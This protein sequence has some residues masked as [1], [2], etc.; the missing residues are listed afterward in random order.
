MKIFRLQKQ[1]FLFFLFVFFFCVFPVFGSYFDSSKFTLEDEIKAKIRFDSTRGGFRY[2]I[3]S[4]IRQTLMGVADNVVV[5]DIEE[6]MN[7]VLQFYFRVPDSQR[8]ASYLKKMHYREEFTENMEALLNRYAISGLEISE[9]KKAIKEKDAEIVKLKVIQ[10]ET[11]IQ[12]TEENLVLE[13]KIKQ[14]EAQNQTLQTQIRDVLQLEKDKQDLNSRLADLIALHRKIALA[15][16]EAVQ[17]NKSITLTFPDSPSMVVYPQPVFETKLLALQEKIAEL[18]KLLK[19]ANSNS[20]FGDKIK[21]NQDFKIDSLES[22]IKD[23]EVKLEENRKL[24]QEQ[25][26]FFQ[27][28]NVLLEAQIKINEEFFQK[29]KK[30]LEA[31]IKDN[32]KKFKDDEKLLKEQNNLL[33]SQISKLE[34]DLREKNNKLKSLLVKHHALEDQILYLTNDLKTSD[35]FREQYSLCVVELQDELAKH[36]S[37]QHDLDLVQE[38]FRN[39]LLDYS[40]L[41]AYKPYLEEELAKAL[42]R[43]SFYEDSHLK[44]LQSL[45]DSLDEERTKIIQLDQEKEDLQKRILFEKEKEHLKRTFGVFSLAQD[46]FN[47]FLQFTQQQNFFHFAPY[48]IETKKIFKAY[49]NDFTFKP[50]YSNRRFSVLFLHFC[51]NFHDVFAFQ[52]FRSLYVDNFQFLG[53]F[54]FLKDFIHQCFLKYD[55]LFMGYSVGYKHYLNSLFK[56]FYSIFAVIFSFIYQLLLHIFPVV[57]YLYETPENILKNNAP[58]GLF[59]YFWQILVG[60]VDA[61]SRLLYLFNSALALMLWGSKIIVEKV[62]TTQ[63]AIIGGLITAATVS[64]SVVSGFIT[65]SPG[66]GVM[67]GAFVKS[68][69]D[70]LTDKISDGMRFMW[71]FSLSMW[72]FFV[73]IFQGT[74]TLTTQSSNF[75][76]VFLTMFV[77]LVIWFLQIVL[78]VIK[79]FFVFWFYFVYYC[80]LEEEEKTNILLL[81]SSSQ[82]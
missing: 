5:S 15:Y 70:F 16:Q 28:K 14:L 46:E 49:A 42:S 58:P 38:K 52:R 11:I 54:Y 25:L 20:L 24:F 53:T 67:T 78:K 22:Q 68:S 65:K 72:Q 45:R 32:E 50:P 30:L 79:Y 82:K 12:L 36:V 18:E 71:G 51:T 75:F 37:L 60:L 64:S 34:K 55:G 73:S 66:I 44:R 17:T 40:H 3:P 77:N 1:L 81:P 33:S 10:S 39:L 7:D 63:G 56:F 31:Q 43:I 80:V 61:L 26:K 35:W 23:L 29:E 41:K 74:L 69:L 8:D 9:L 27:E 57:R 13:K 4:N 2:K 47:R 48:K 21:K 76:V 19:D 6:T 62:F 59:N